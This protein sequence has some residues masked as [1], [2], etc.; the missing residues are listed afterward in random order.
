VSLT[1]RRQMLVSA[2]FL[3]FVYLIELL[4]TLTLFA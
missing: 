1:W 3:L 2:L 4:Y